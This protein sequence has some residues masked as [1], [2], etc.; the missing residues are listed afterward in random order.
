MTT[1][2]ARKASIDNLDPRMLAG[3]SDPYSLL[4]ELRETCPV[5]RSEM[6][7]GFWNLFRYQDVCA[8]AVDATTFSSRDVTIPSE[9]LIAKPAPIMID[10][11]R[12]MEYRHPLLRKFAPQVVAE[13]EPSI[14][15]KVRQM[16]DA[17]LGRGHADLCDELFVP[18]PAFAALRLLNLPESDFPSFSRWAQLAFTIPEPGSADA[19]WELEVAAYFAPLYDQKA[20]SEA[21]D[22]PSIARRIKIDGREIELMEFVM[23]LVTLVTAGLDTTS[24]ASANIALLLDEQPELRRQL[25]EHPDLIPNAVEELLRYL[26]PLPMLARTATRD[27]EV[28]GVRIP[29]GQK[30]ALHWLAANHDPSEFDEPEK[31]DFGRPSSRHV[32]F[33][34]GPHRCI[35]MHLARIEVR[36]M[37][38]ELITRIPDYAVVRDQVVRT[39]GVTR[40]VQH[41]PITFTP[42]AVGA[43]IQ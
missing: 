27:V 26:S 15:R 25:I 12:H 41:L 9:P 23:L 40:Q 20:G 35:G 38:E 14:R 8:A 7:G 29:E 36:V 1:G 24:N 42:S 32:A 22:I 5:G 17:F 43:D 2:H 33:G 4:N 18:F 3:L 37:L 39:P 6:Y 19:N 28:S 31:V 21:D 16:M 10:P 30:V 34:I 11:P 13:L